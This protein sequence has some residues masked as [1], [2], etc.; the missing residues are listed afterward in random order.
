[1]VDRMEKVHKEIMRVF[2]QVLQAEADLPPDMLV[3]VT[4]AA[5]SRNLRTSTVWLSVL[6]AEQGETVLTA[7]QG[8]LYDL[9][10]SFNRR[11]ALRPLPRL[12]LALDPAAA[13]GAV[14][15]TASRTLAGK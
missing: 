12:R 9:Q 4:R 8:Q 15:H 14:L 2:G 3:T 11:V 7:L 13:Y 6:P 5:A 1:M 10:G